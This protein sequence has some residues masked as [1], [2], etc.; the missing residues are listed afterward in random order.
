MIEKQKPVWRE[1]LE[2]LLV[3]LILAFTIRSFVIAPFKIPS[4]SMVPTLEIGDYIFV[5][6]Y[7]YGLRIPLTDIQ[8]FPTSAE[9]GDVAVFDFPEDRSKDYIKRI[10]GVPGDEIRYKENRLFVNGEEMPLEKLGRRIY[11]QANDNADTSGLYEETLL[12]VKHHVLR[13]SY[14]I[15]DGEWIVPEGYYFVLGDNRNNS[16][17][18]RFWGYV[19]QSYLVGKAVVVWWSWDSHLSEVRWTRLGKLL[20]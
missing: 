3:I 13:K 2:S 6:R 17:D 4:S 19:P 5:V 18:S 16:R 10:V 12:G 9:R 20:H 15:K 1:W 7:P 14:S 11:F 8:F